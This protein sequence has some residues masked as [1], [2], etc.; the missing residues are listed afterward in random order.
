MI[1]VISMVSESSKPFIDTAIL[2]AVEWNKNARIYIAYETEN[3]S[4]ELVERLKDWELA[5]NKVVLVPAEKRPR[6]AVAHAHNDALKEALMDEDNE[7]FARLDLDN[8][9]LDHSLKILKDAINSKKVDMVYGDHLKAIWRG[10]WVIWGCS[11]APPTVYAGELIRELN[12]IPGNSIMYTRELAEKCGFW[13]IEYEGGWDVEFYVRALVHGFRLEKVL[14]GIIPIEVT[15]YHEN[16]A[17]A[18]SVQGDIPEETRW[19]KWR[20]RLWENRGV[21]RQIQVRRM[22]G[23]VDEKTLPGK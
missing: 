23:D 18:K 3:C 5:N 8:Y 16:S 22:L 9:F 12:K 4:P 1:A 10:E 7:Y 20:K 14:D 6:P 21:Y 17:F 19:Y 11:I 13:N 15:R 2:S